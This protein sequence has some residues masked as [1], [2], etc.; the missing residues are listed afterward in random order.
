MRFLI[1]LLCLSFTLSANDGALEWLEGELVAGGYV[2]DGE[3]PLERF[4][5]QFAHADLD[6]LFI[7]SDGNVDWLQEGKQVVEHRHGTLHCQRCFLDSLPD[8]VPLLVDQLIACGVDEVHLRLEA[9][10]EDPLPFI[11]HAHQQGIRVIAAVNEM[12]EETLPYDAVHLLVPSPSDAQQMRVEMGDAPLLADGLPCD[13][14]LS[15]EPG[16]LTEELKF[17]MDLVGH[18]NSHRL[19]LM[20]DLDWMDA[21][22]YELLY[23]EL[24]EDGYPTPGEPLWLETDDYGQLYTFFADLEQADIVRLPVDGVMICR[25]GHADDLV[26]LYLVSTSRQLVLDHLILAL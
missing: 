26:H 1:F 14:N 22:R 16:H 21:A 9:C 8:N 4:L 15:L 10:E 7:G 3:A 24:A 20:L 12:P 2:A 23:L 13:L 5:Q 18:E 11:T 25:D 17:W 19:H 6:A